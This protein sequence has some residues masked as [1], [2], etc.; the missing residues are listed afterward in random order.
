MTNSIYSG[1]RALYYIYLS[2]K[3]VLFELIYN[4]KEAFDVFIA[5]CLKDDK[6]RLHGKKIGKKIAKF[7]PKNFTK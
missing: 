7:L 2:R 4:D 3:E 1:V 5:A 6:N